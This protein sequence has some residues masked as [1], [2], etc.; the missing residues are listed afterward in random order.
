MLVLDEG[1]KAIELLVTFRAA[2]LFSA[3][4]FLMTLQIIISRKTLVAGQTAEYFV[5][6]RRTFLINRFI[7]FMFIYIRLCCELFVTLVA[8]ERFSYIVVRFMCLQ[9]V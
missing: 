7:V 5:I 3:M 6:I 2:V 4:T 9:I 8:A 1:V